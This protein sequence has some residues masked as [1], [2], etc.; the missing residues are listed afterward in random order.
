VV[1]CYTPPPAK[2]P[3][4]ILAAW[5]H[6][7]GKEC[8]PFGETAGGVHRDERPAAATRPHV[9]IMARG[10][11]A[12]KKTKPKR[13]RPRRTPGGL[14]ALGVALLLL[15]AGGVA[16]VWG[17]WQPPGLVMLLPFGAAAI[18]LGVAAAV[19]VAA[20][21][22]FRLSYWLDPEQLSIR[23]AGATEVI[24][25]DAI[26]GIYA[27]SR[28]GRL[29][30]VRG[31]NWPGYHVGV[32]PN[33]ALGPL[34][35][36]CTDLSIDALSVIVTAER[37]YLLSPTD[38][39]EFRRELIQRI[40]ATDTVPTRSI[41]VARRGQ[42]GLPHPLLVAT[43]AAAVALLVAVLT[44]TLAN[45]Q[46]LPETISPPML[47][48]T[49]SSSRTDV[50]RLP[51]LGA[52]LLGVNLLLALALRARERGAIV[53]LCATACLIEAVILVATLR[54]LS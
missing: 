26:E 8:G 17:L 7:S 31:L 40:E 2:G 16:L 33:S 53:L 6:P 44:T 24:P 37:T 29:Q 15:L 38:P 10:E 18:V 50:L 3:G 49:I 35:V 32:V 20:L 23:W 45:Y 13:W 14:L 36:F 9:S 51:L 11:S 48:D 39:A 28:V 4:L 54:L 47:A 1:G 46:A 5:R 22:Y 21:G 52:I 42:G 27:G 12:P 41:P 43:I 19:A 34:R 25:L 30:Q